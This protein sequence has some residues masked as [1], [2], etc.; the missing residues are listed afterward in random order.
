VPRAQSPA[1]ADAAD[2]ECF[3]QAVLFPFSLFLPFCVSV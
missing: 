1:C 2:C 3:F